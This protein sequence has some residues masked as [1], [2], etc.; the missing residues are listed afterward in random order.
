MWVQVSELV[1]EVWLGVDD[2]CL[3]YWC[4][5]V[6]LWCLEGGSVQVDVL[7]FFVCC[8]LEVLR[9]VVDVCLYWIWFEWEQ[10]VFLLGVGQVVLKL[11]DVV[12]LMGMFMVIFDLL[13]V[14]RIEVIEDID[15]RC[16]EVVWVVWVFVLVFDGVQEIGML[17]YSGDLSLLV[18]YF[19]DLFKL[20]EMD[21]D[22]V[23]C[24]VVFID[25]WF[26]MVD[27]FCLVMS[28]GYMVFLFLCGLV[29]IGQFNVLFGVGFVD[30][31]DYVNMVDFQ[32][33]I[34][35]LQICLVLEVL[36]G[37]NVLVVWCQF[38]GWEILQFCFVELIVLGW[39]L[40]IDL[41]CGQCGIQFEMLS[42][43]DL[44][45]K[46]FFYWRIVCCWCWFLMSRWDCC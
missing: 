37:I 42:G 11:G 38:G 1:V 6:I 27:V 32:F 29:V 18:V 26:G 46:L 19:L 5:V 17:F 31:F 3:D 35:V 22:D 39:Y 15:C 25:F 36:V 43:V 14:V 20:M 8:F 7:D 28:S 13:F 30:V 24:L 2:I 44:V 34:G 10:V 45:W 23:V 21:L 16:M 4:C 12:W 9:L 41:F 40:F 33:Y